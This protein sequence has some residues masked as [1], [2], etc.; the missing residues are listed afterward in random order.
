M[1]GYGLGHKQVYNDLK[2]RGLTDSESKY[3][4]NKLTN[5]LRSCGDLH[6]CD[7]FRFSVNND[8]DKYD[9]IRKLGCCGFYDEVVYLKSGKKVEFGF[10]YGH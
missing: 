8:N 5:A 7:N 9:K 6:C 4:V 3:V 10:N 2:S 1:K